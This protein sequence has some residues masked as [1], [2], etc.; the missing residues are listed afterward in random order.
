MLSDKH[1][2]F[3]DNSDRVFCQQIRITFRVELYWYYLTELNYKQK[4]SCMMKYVDEFRF[5]GMYS[6]RTKIR[7]EHY[8]QFDSAR[9]RLNPGLEHTTL[10]FRACYAVGCDCT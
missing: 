4:Y 8:W 9:S 5:L 3:S 1:I 6:S 10:N 2:L 7:G